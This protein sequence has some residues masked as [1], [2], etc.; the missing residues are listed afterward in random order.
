MMPSAIYRFFI[1]DGRARWAAYKVLLAVMM[2]ICVGGD[3]AFGIPEKKLAYGSAF[4]LFVLTVCAVV[5]YAA[6]EK[7]TIEHISKRQRVRKCDRRIRDRRAQGKEQ[8]G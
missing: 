5:R 1:L 7:R 3:L 6:N 2:L 8:H 4:A